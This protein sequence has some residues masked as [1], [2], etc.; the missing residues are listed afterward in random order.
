MKE[1]WLLTRR[2]QSSGAYAQNRKQNNEAF[3]LHTVQEWSQSCKIDLMERANDAQSLANT[4]VCASDALQRARRGAE[5]S[6]QEER[7]ASK[8]ADTAKREAG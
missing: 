8:A 3:K 7:E 5:I 2:N 6:H 1:A 4:S